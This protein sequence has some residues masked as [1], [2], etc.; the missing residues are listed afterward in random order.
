MNPD[1]PNH[2]FARRAQCLSRAHGHAEH[3]PRQQVHRSFIYLEEQQS[4]G[5][6]MMIYELIDIN[7]TKDELPPYTT[8]YRTTRP[9]PIPRKAEVLNLVD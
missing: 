7:R 9:P 4:S 8:N 6:M 3:N 1:R 2:D 5:K